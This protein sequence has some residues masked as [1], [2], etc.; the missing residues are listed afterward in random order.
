MQ[1]ETPTTPTV[2]HEETFEISEIAS[3]LIHCLFIAFWAVLVFLVFYAPFFFHFHI[4][5]SP[6]RKSVTPRSGFKTK[7]AH[8]FF[9]LSL[10]KKNYLMMSFQSLNSFSVITSSYQLFY[11]PLLSF[12]VSSMLFSFFFS[13]CSFTQVA[14]GYKSCSTLV[15]QMDCLHSRTLCL[16]SKGVRCFFFGCVPR[17]RTPAEGKT[18]KREGRAK[19]RK[20]SDSTWHSWPSINLFFPFHYILMFIYAYVFWLTERKKRE[21]QC[22][23]SLLFNRF[24]SFADLRLY[25]CLR[26]TVDCCLKF[27]RALGLPFFLDSLTPLAP[28]VSPMEDIA[29]ERMRTLFYFILF[30]T[31]FFVV[32]LYPQRP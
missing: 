13:L 21:K 1:Q 9:Q 12:S 4:F 18:G 20:T 30:Y 24:S 6:D 27:D 11:I 22:R 25:G 19:K 29:V 32:Y 15:V 17:L 16:D 31:F 23:K 14:E 5:F 10:K 8:I 28:I 2:E 26:Q 3:S 7:T